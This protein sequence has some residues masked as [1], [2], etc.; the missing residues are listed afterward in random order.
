MLELVFVIVVI[1]IL[2]AAI[3]P[4][5]DRDVLYEAAEK[6]QGHIKYTQHLAMTDNVYDDSEQNWYYERWKIDLSNP[7][8]YSISKG[9]SAGSFFGTN[10]VAQDPL[11]RNLMNGAVNDDYDLDSKYNVA[12]TSTDGTITD[13]VL[14]FDQLG[15]PYFIA[16]GG[17]E[18]A[19]AVANIMKNDLQITL[20]D[21]N[22][23]T[24]TITIR[25]ETGYSS[26]TFP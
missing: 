12:Y 17:G 1:G 15:R 22:G 9:D 10:T 24:A 23:D 4:R 18:P 11:T 6:L 21:S 5:M 14:S 2:A 7:S 8:Q 16:S 19:S 20:T 3:I 13:G 26:I 25:A